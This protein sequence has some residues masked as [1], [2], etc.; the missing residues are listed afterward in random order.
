MKK[1]LVC[2]VM[3]WNKKTGSDTFS[4]LMQGY[5]VDDI[6]NI[7]IREGYPDSDA[8]KNYYKISEGL[9]IKSILKRNLKT[10]KRIITDG[11]SSS[12][13]DDN[14][15]AISEQ[16]KKQQ[17]NR[18]YLKLF[19]RELLWKLG[20]WKTKELDAFLEEF[21]PD[22]V[23]FAMEGYIHFARMNRYILK[24][25]G[26]KG[27]GY[28]WDDNF[29]YKKSKKLG[30]KIFRFF[31][32]RS[33]K[34]LAKLCTNFFAISPKTK[35]EADK[36][37]G[38]NCE[39]L[40]KPIDFLNKPF[41]ETELSTPLKMVY[42]GK[43]IIGRYDTVELI[44]RALDE[45][46]KDEVKIE[47]DVY[48]MTEIEDT[49]KLSKHVH[50]KGAVAQTEVAQIQKNADI[51]LFAEATEGEHSQA[52]RL[53]FSTKITDYLG[54][55]KCIFAVGNKDVAPMEYL[56][57]ED[58][59][60][61][62]YDYET[63]LASLNNIVNNPELVKEYAKKAYDLGKRNHDKKLIQERLFSKFQEER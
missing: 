45:I 33:L 18:S 16:Y 8:C 57:E 23:F 30:Y 6:A 1:V 10:G 48:T 21:K 31:Q 26:A 42:T 61:T 22:V 60:I 15:I 14:D 37:F 7:Y 54:S 56:K 38:I 53:S 50:L 29:T 12:D 51:L 13:L 9:V 32:R 47:L 34:K 44:G 2:S 5:E 25:T 3:C 62:A 46:N 58:G 20:K 28:F 24:K 55:G 41:E 40:T 36:A 63:V 4:T 39:V 27:I 11:M 35:R 43:L 52:A 49:G 59:A 17:K 19:A